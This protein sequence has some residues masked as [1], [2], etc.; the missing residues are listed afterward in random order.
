M[1]FQAKVIEILKQENSSARPSPELST[2]GNAKLKRDAI[3]NF[4]LPAGLTCPG[5]GACNRGFCY[6]QI[7]NYVRTNVIRRQ[8]E[9]F[10]ASKRHYFVDIML[11]RIFR[12]KGLEYV[13]IHDAGDFYSDDYISKWCE[14]IKEAPRVKFYAYTKSYTHFDLVSLWSLENMNLIQ[15]IGSKNDSLIDYSKPHAR[16]FTSL[17]ALNEAGYVDCSTY[18]LPAAQG[19]SKVGLVIHGQKKKYFV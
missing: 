6:A 14:I 8:V 4:S 16:I 12:I 3:A 9:N 15:S 11:D 5:A 13:R 10:L 18:D 19:V 1:S 7:G 2:N 17:E